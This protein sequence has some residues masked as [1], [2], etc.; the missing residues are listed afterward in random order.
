MYSSGVNA[1][2]GQVCLR[3]DVLGLLF[4]VWKLVCALGCFVNLKDEFVGIWCRVLM[5]QMVVLLILRLGMPE[6]RCMERRKLHL[7]Q[8]WA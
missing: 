6:Y 3:N 4:E 8:T 5:V 1:N 2:S 7:V